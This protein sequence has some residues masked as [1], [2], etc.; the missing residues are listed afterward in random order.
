MDKDYDVVDDYDDDD[1]DDNNNKFIS[2]IARLGIACFASGRKLV[3]A[4]LF[5]YS[6]FSL[7]LA[8]S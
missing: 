4:L 6:I 1:D 3:L 8:Y 2:T 7:S 5:W